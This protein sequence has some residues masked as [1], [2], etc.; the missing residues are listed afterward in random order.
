MTPSDPEDPYPLAQEELFI[1]RNREGQSKGFQHLLDFLWELDKIDSI[2]NVKKAC[3][4]PWEKGALSL[5]PSQM[6]EK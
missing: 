1:L 5:S 3:I 2:C 6:S 4:V